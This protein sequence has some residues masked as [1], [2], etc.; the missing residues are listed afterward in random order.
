MTEREKYKIVTTADCDYRALCKW[1]TDYTEQH[2]LGGVMNDTK[3]LE[4]QQ[5]ILE[6][7]PFPPP[8][9]IKRLGKEVDE[10][11]LDKDV[12]WCGSWRNYYD[13]GMPQLVTIQYV[14]VRPRLAVHRGRLISPEIIDCTKEFLDILHRLNIPYEQEG[15][16]F[17]IYGY[18]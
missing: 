10:H 7:L 13:E 5:A 14:K 12:W 9:V 11:V 4:L 3:W 18:R 2:G 6:E 1:V 17:T 16:I 15:H 8:N